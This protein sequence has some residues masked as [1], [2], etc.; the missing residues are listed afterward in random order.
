MLST[1]VHG[2]IRLISENPQSTFSSSD[3]IA[4][5][6]AMM[7]FIGVLMTSFLAF[8]MNKTNKKLQEDLNQKNINASLTAKARI[9]WIQE[10]RKT[11]SELVALYFTLLSLEKDTP[12]LVELENIQKKSELLILYFGPE[13][14]IDKKESAKSIKDTKTNR[15]KNEHVVENIQSIF[16]KCNKFYTDVKNGKVEKLEENI[17]SIRNSMYSEPQYYN[18]TEVIDFNGE[19]T[20]ITE[21]IPYEEDVQKYNEAKN[22]YN[23]F[24]YN[25]DQIKQDILE[26]RDIIRIYLKIE[27]DIAKRGK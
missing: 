27:W 2:S 17:S 8:K 20:F 4:L 5:I 11:T 3:I 23:L 10:V 26:L 9:A 12:T 24:I 6:A 15:G 19:P 7:S 22:D 13:Y 1:I 25:R 14:E 18:T 21:P 16:L